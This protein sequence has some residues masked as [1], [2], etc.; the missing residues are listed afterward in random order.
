VPERIDWFYYRKTC[1]G[2]RLARQFLRSQ[3]CAV[4]EEVDA[5]AAP[6]DADAAV[7]L[8]RQVRKLVVAWHGEVRTWELAGGKFFKFRT[9]KPASGRRP[10]GFDAPHGAAIEGSD[11]L[12]YNVLRNGLLRTPALRKGGTLLVGFSEV[13]VERVFRG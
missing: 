9:F 11:T 10:E 8:V 6:V 13:A 3:G 7:E 5:A 1:R 12:W 4:A 2:S